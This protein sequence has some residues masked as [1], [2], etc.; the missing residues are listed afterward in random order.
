MK[1]Q[2]R[3][4]LLFSVFLVISTAYADDG[5]PANEPSTTPSAAPMTTP[6]TAT[7]APSDTTPATNSQ[8]VT[9]T[10]DTGDMQT[11]IDQSVKD[12]KL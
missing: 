9:Y 4:S 7:A 3:L 11:A 10:I 6:T 5:S 12:Y 8:P 1:I 2:I